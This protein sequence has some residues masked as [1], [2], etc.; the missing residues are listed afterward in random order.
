MDFNPELSMHTTN[1]QVQK[2]RFITIAAYSE[3]LL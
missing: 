3:L 1:L 2:E